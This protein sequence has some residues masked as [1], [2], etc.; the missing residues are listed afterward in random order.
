V[1]EAIPPQGILIM[2]LEQSTW[3]PHAH[4]LCDKLPIQTSSLPQ[5]PIVL[6]L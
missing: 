4:F 1:E 6:S 5:I 2:H 3:D